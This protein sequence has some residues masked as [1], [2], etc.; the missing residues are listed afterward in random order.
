MEQIFRDYLFTK[1]ILVCDYSEED[2]AECSTNPET[3]CFGALVALA[4]KFGIRITDGANMANMQMVKDAAMN[5]GEYVPEPFYRGFPQTV[6]ELTNEQQLFDQLFRRLAFDEETEPKDFRILPLA[7]AEDILKVSV[8]ELLSGTRPLNIDQTLL[9]RNAWS[10]YGKD[11]LPERI[12][13]K[14][15]AVELLC[16][17]RDADTFAKY[18][19]LPDVI[20]VLECIQYNTYHSENLKK[21]NLK[22]QDRKL[23]TNLMD[24]LFRR[25]EG[26]AKDGNRYMAFFE[27]QGQECFEKRKIWRGLLHHIHYKP[28]GQIA[29]TFVNDIREGEN[30]S[31]YSVFEDCMANGAPVDAAEYL[32]KTKGSGALL[33]NLDYILSR[34]GS[35]EEVKGVF[36]CLTD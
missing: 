15:T 32:K 14:K 3:E 25:A 18:L 33:R 16:E 13:C 17:T 12:G 5:L 31:A 2:G 30:C 4:K 26:E 29:M 35:G 19:T 24:I 10:T 11:I 20:K 36:S 1:H 9:V 23:I 34:C 21:L 28:K 7:E 22:N 8:W 27:K 6:R